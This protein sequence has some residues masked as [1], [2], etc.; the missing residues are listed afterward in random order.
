M[1]AMHTVACNKKKKPTTK[2][3]SILQEILSRDKSRVEGEV[4]RLCFWAVFST[5]NPTL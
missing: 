1:G 4:F 2:T 5:L 3:V